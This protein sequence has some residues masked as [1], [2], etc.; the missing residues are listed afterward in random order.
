MRIP[1][2]FAQNELAIHCELG[3]EMAEQPAMIGGG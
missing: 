1:L 3:I 2:G